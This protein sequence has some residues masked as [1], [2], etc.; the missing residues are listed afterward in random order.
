MSAIC[1]LSA[2]SITDRMPRRAILPA[3][4]LMCAVLLGIN[5]GLSAVLDRQTRRG[6]GSVS[7]SVAQGALAAYFL[8]NCMYSFTYTPLQGVLPVESLTTTMRAKGL[9]AS[10]FIVS[11][12]GFI[13]QFAGP[14]GLA[15]L[16]YKYIYV[17]VGWDVVEVSN[18]R[19]IIFLRGFQIADCIRLSS[20][21]SSVS[22]PR[23]VRSRSSTGSTS[24]PTPSRPRRCT[25]RLSSPR[26]ASSPT[27]RRLRR[28]FKHQ[29]PGNV[30][31][32][33]RP[34]RVVITF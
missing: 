30:G 2:A 1:A 10:G 22:S 18:I 8:F 26:V 32:W 27:S 17:F 31:R 33:R 5:S 13:N 3:G 9:A 15:N 14:I 21:T 23:A 19:A 4:T 12:I 25:R 20:G 11:A 24:S 16:G 6:D 7:S 34:G 28:S 29:N